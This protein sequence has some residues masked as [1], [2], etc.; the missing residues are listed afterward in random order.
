MLDANIAAKALF[1]KIR[2]YLD[3]SISFMDIREIVA[4]IPELQ[5]PKII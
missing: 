2:N 4:K 1:L 5:I 3:I